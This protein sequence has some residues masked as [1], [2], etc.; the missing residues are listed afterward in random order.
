MRSI[1]RMTSL[2]AAVLLFGAGG[3]TAG[4]PPSLG[5]LL[6]VPV[7]S[8]IP[9]G[10]Q[11]RTVNLAATLTV[12]NADRA[13]PIVLKKVDY[14]DSEGRRVSA[15]LAR[16]RELRP[17]AAAHFFLKESDRSG[18]VAA[19]FLV[20]W[21]SAGGAAVSPPVVEAVMISTMS[22]MGIAFTSGGRV[23]EERR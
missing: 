23:I 2:L 14:Y 22:A 10:N 13:R 19:S 15:F 5:Q 18:G 16:E 7:Y 21:E 6:L 20:E 9:F 17:L 11:G 1:P 3:A 12:R 4:E 8:E